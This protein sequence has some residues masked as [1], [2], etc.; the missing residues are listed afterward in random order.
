MTSV[1]KVL[2]TGAG[3]YVGSILVPKLL[4]E[5]FQVVAFDSFVFGE[6][7]QASEN[8]SSLTYVRGNISHLDPSLLDDIDAVIHLAAFSNDPSCELDAW[9]TREVNQ[10]A[11]VRLAKLAKEKGVSRFLFAS[12]CSVYGATNGQPSTEESPLR[13]ISLYAQCKVAVEEELAA[14]A[15][16]AFCTTSLRK[17]TLFGVSPRMRFDLVVNIMA[18]NA[19]KT[20]SISVHGDGQQWRPFLHVADAADAYVRCLSG[21]TAVISGKAFNLVAENTRVVDL[22]NCIAQQV[23]GTELVFDGHNN[24]SR[25]Y[26]VDGSRFETEFDF[27]PRFSIQ[28]GIEEVIGAIESNQFDDFEDSIYHTVVKWKDLLGNPAREGGS[29]TRDHFLPFALPQLGKEEEDEVIDTLRSGW[30]TTGPKTKR[31]E[32]MCAEYVG[33]KHAIALNSCTGALHLAVAG[34]DI[35]PGDEVITTPISWPATANVVIHQGAKPVFVDVE[36]DTLNIDPQKIEAAVTSRTKA[37][38]PVHMA[39]QPCDMAAIRL[40][41]ERHGLAVIEDAAHAIGAAYHSQRIGSISR[42]TAFSFYPIKNMTTIEGGV[43]A[44]DDDELAERAR[45]LSLHGINKDAWKRYSS[46][47][48]LHWHLQEPGFKYNMTDV[49]ASLGLHQ[50]KRL[51]GF[52]EKR[53]QFAKVYD[54]AF[55]DVPAIEPLAHRAG[56]RHAH[57]LYIIKLNLE[58]LTISR[59]E[60][61]LAL[62]AENIGVGVHFISMHLQPYYQQS[63]GMRTE[64]FPVAENLSK[65][66]L[67]L[68]LYPKM[69]EADLSDVVAAV[70]KIAWAYRNT[71]WAAKASFTPLPQPPHR[72]AETK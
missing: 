41:A 12:S 50:L 32:D 8:D 37:I 15:D 45:V 5:G 59:D 52:I 60:F 20:H 13:P 6:P 56:I 54:E 44:T 29:P 65:Q 71:I 26:V 68:P 2:V 72:L 57:H 16:E 9:S 49:Q 10:C 17:A 35:G 55:A 58:Q 22:A 43:L 28:S 30:I 70:R 62:K 1:S 7:N 46:E 61:M 69:S 21:N 53:K 47:G 38:I 34:L 11:S 4:A 67:S 42:A 18:V 33:C 51:D 23:S 64:D 66:I 39:G 14:L 36:P 25:D 40:I 27:H 24:D 63:L 19:I 3:G 48:S 31:F